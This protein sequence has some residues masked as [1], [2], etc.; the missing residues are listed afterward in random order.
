MN[1]DINRAN[2]YENFGLEI[3]PDDV[4]DSSITEICDENDRALEGMTSVKDSPRNTYN[5]S[6]FPRIIE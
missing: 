1:S 6:D 2:E 5:R 4:F 3:V